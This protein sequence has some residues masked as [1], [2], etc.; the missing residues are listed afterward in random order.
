[1]SMV[2]VDAKAFKPEA[3]EDMAAEMITA[4]NNPINPL[5]K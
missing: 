2:V 1:M 3:V 5:G 4:N